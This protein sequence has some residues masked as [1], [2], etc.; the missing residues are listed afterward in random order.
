MLNEIYSRKNRGKVFF[1][2]NCEYDLTGLTNDN[3]FKKLEG[4]LYRGSHFIRASKTIYEHDDKREFV[5]FWDSMRILMSSLGKIGDVLKFPKM[6]IPRLLLN[7]DDLDYE[8]GL[9]LFRAE[10]RS[11]SARNKYIEYCLND[12]ILLYKALNDFQNFIWDNYYTALKPTIS[13]IAFSIFKR[14]FMNKTWHDCN[15]APNLAFKDSYYGGRV[16]VFKW[17]RSGDL[18]Y[19]DINSLY[20]YEGLKEYP[21]PFKLYYT[22]DPDIYH[23]THG[24]GLFNIKTPDDM[25]IPILPYRMKGK[26]FFPLGEFSSWYNFN[27]IRYAEENGYEVEFIKGFFAYETKYPLKKYYEK[28]Y[29]HRKQYSKKHYF[30]LII[31]YLM[32]ALQGRF[33]LK[34]ENRE[35]MFDYEYYNNS[36]F[37]EGDWNFTCLQSDGYGIAVNSLEPFQLTETTYYTIPSYLT[38]YARIDLHK[39]LSKYADSLVYCD[40]DSMILEGKTLD[41]ELINTDLGAWKCEGD[42]DSGWF[43]GCKFYSLLENEAIWYKWNEIDVKIKGLSMQ[44]KLNIIG[45][46]PASKRIISYYKTQESLR[47]NKRAGSKKITDKKINPYVFDKRKYDNSIDYRYEGTKT[48][49]LTINTNDQRFI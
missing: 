6:Q 29:E 48:Y 22:K 4:V 16:D 45:E 8:D 11:H 2:H 25:H 43:S 20:P 49:P 12:C 34:I 32:N 24:C 42:F 33:G 15:L 7:P 27:E 37:V 9:N 19:Y 3:I 38:S 28:M 1:G 36:E 21:H 18:H 30:N 10:W 39:N 13:S 17:G 31:K 44:D 35:Y 46:L 23:D 41:T 47:R 26:L 40:T 14:N 5:R